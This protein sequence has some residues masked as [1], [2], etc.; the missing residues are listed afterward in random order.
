M[1][2]DVRVAAP[3]ILGSLALAASM[4]IVMPAVSRA[5]TAG[6]V[7]TIAG[8]PGLGPARSVGLA[9]FALATFGT[10]V[11][12]S[13]DQ[14]GVVRDLNLANGALTVLAGNGTHGSS[15]DGGPATQ[16]Q[17]EE[18]EGVAVDSK[19]DVYVSDSFAAR[20]RRIDAATGVITTVAGTGVTGWTGDGGPAADARLTQPAGLAFD[21]HDNLYVAD[22]GN[23]TVRRVDAQTGIISTVA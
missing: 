6:D 2:R 10:H 7:Q 17:L 5:A 21:S 3:R 15:G 1:G 14:W 13:D 23:S 12:I 19:G 9:T 18:P 16:A 11:Y 22:T 20:V 4:L 8:S